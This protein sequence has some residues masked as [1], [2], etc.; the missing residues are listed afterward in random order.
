LSDFLLS[1]KTNVLDRW[2]KHST[3]KTNWQFTHLV[4]N[5][6]NSFINYM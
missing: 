2:G 3:P 5:N 4:S 1:W 6:D